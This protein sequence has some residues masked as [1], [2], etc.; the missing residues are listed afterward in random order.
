MIFSTNFFILR[1]I[2]FKIDNLPKIDL[3]RIIRLADVKKKLLLKHCKKSI[4]NNIRYT[5]R[6]R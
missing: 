4:F 1:D 2:S 3:E 5:V 6:P